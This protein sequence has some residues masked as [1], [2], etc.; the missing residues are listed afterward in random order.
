[1]EQLRKGKSIVM[2]SQHTLI[3]GWTDKTFSL[4]T[5]LCLA[6]ESRADGSRG[7]VIVILANKHTEKAEM[8]HELE[9]NIDIPTRRGSRFVCRVGSTM[10]ILDLRKV[11]VH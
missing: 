2:E 8:E 6:N 11:S 4:I 7:G 9:I 3:L 10:N 5:E 1:M